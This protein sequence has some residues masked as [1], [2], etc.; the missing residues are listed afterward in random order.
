MLIWIYYVW[1]WINISYP[2]CSHPP[3]DQI[4]L[5]VGMFTYY[6]PP[7]FGC[8][9]LIHNQMTNPHPLIATCGELR[10]CP[11][12][13]ALSRG[14]AVDMVSSCWSVMSQPWLTKVWPSETI[15]K[16]DSCCRISGIVILWTEMASSTVILWHYQ[17][18]LISWSALKLLLLEQGRDRPWTS[19]SQE[20]LTSTT[21]LP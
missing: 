20:K 15:T 2:S 7:F 21:G 5:A 8:F 10:R 13:A 16:H 1:L 18:F 4:S 19:K 12:R 11:A 9:I 6:I 3:R 17:P 14:F